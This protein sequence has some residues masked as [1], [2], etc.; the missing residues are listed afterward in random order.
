MK[1]TKMQGLGNDYLYVFG[2]VPEDAAEWSLRLSDRHFGPGADGMIWITPSERADFGMRIFNADGSEAK[3]CG[4]GIRCVGKYVRDKGHT[5]KRSLTVETLSGV[6]R[7]SLHLTEGK[8]SSVTVDMGRAAVSGERELDLG[9]EKLRC[10]PVD[11]GNPHAVTF[12][13]DAEAVPL[14]TLGPRVEKHPAFPGG[15]NAEFVQPLD[16]RRLRMRVWE[17]GSGVTLA[18]GTGA[19]ASAAAAVRRGFCPPGEPIDVLLDGGTLTVRVSEEGAV[20][21]TGPC[22]FVCEGDTEIC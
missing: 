7:L 11:V 1:F 9:T 14:E 8:V 18:C 6:K 20:E 5:D 19:C 13:E 22:E 17:R 2:P 15:V 10:T 16:A 3:M 12:V 21:M 4:N